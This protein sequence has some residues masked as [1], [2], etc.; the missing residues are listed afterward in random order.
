MQLTIN[1][2][3]TTL[4]APAG[5]A[6]LGLA[7]PAPDAAR[8]GVIG[9]GD[10]YAATLSRVT[11]GVESA[12][13]VVHITATGGG[14]L[15]VERAK[16]GTTALDWQAGEAISIRVTA[17]LLQ[18]L[19]SQVSEL[20]SAIAALD[21]RVAALEGGATPTLLSVTV[22]VQP[23]TWAGYEDGL[24]SVSPG[25]L[26]IPGQ[27]TF[28]IFSLGFVD[29]ASLYVVFT[30]QFDPLAIQS[31]DVEGAGVFLVSEA[32]DASSQN[33]GGVWY[34]IY[35]W[36]TGTSD[37]FA[38]DGQQRSVTVTFSAAD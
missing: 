36:A 13:E 18:S 34:T 19:F 37:W 14:V 27:G 8:L 33:L 12:W 10:Y 25:G 32:V 21:V 38:S 4:E 17:A 6:A 22:G 29:G 1:N 26:E 23:G 30:G 24:G 16:E 3:A 35:E 28:P 15:T 9:P 31:F 2:W 20:S 7:V 5:S 11:S